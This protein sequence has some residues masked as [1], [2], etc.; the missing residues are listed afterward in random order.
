M[1]IDYEILS[2]GGQYTDDFDA[3]DI[4]ERELLAFKPHS[5]Y[6]YNLILE[7]WT[8]FMIPKRFVKAIY[9]REGYI[10]LREITA[11]FFEVIDLKELEGY[12]KLVEH[13]KYA[14]KR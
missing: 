1:G 5:E 12:S 11:A 8:M 2:L 9:D 13:G 3:Q 10:D 6:R 14:H 7:L 4:A